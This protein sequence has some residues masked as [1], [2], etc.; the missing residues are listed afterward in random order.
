MSSDVRVTYYGQPE[1]TDVDG[2]PDDDVPWRRVTCQG[3]P[4]GTDV[5]DDV[6]WRRVTCQGQPEGTHVCLFVSLLN[7]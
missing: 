5:D 2:L 3:Q 6:P 1:G 4:K 7:V